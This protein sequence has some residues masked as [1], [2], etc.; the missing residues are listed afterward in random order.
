MRRNSRI[1]FIFV[2]IWVSCVLYYFY[3]VNNSDVSKTF[4]LCEIEMSSFLY[5]A[6]VKEHM[7]LRLMY[8]SCALSSEIEIF[9]WQQE[10]S[11]ISLNLNNLSLLVPCQHAYT[12]PL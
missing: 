8:K 11:T 4:R 10:V 6:S 7:S 5:S 1:L 12:E 2:L 9:T 3:K